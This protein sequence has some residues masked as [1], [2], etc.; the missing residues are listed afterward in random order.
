MLRN[1]FPSLHWGTLNHCMWDAAYAAC[2]KALPA[3]QRGT[4]PLI[5]VCEPSRCRNS[6][7]TRAHAPVW[8][9]EEHDLQV[10]IGERRVSTPRL[11]S[12]QSRLVDVQLVTDAWKS[13]RGHLM[14]VS[15]ATE[16]KLRAAMQRLLAGTP[17]HTDGALTKE[18]LAREARVSHATVHRATDILAEWNTRVDRSILRTPGEVRRDDDIA[19]LRR[20]LSAA[21]SEITELRGK[22]DALATVTANLYHETQALHQ[23][24][25]H[26]GMLHVLPTPAAES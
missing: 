8:L 26:R 7:V 18:N 13:K 2:Q 9:A 17:A 20:K 24:L 14:A 15:A 1:E 6:V 4:A 5:G 3:D 11:A 22:L 12:L 19:A 16:A 21:N 10:M 25:D 23:K